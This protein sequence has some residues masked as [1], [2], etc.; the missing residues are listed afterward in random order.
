MIATTEEIYPHTSDDIDES[1][2][3][4]NILMDEF[5][6]S[7]PDDASAEGSGEVIFSKN[8]NGDAPLE[9]K[10]ASKYQT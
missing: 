10:V 1:I 6:Q 7:Q 4:Y 8:Q 9:H 3:M 5:S 2:T